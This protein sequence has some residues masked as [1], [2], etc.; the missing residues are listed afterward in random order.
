VEEVDEEEEAEE[1]VVF[2]FDLH[3]TK[4]LVQISNKKMYFFIPV[5]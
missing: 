3:A 2:F 1:D 5:F 4:A